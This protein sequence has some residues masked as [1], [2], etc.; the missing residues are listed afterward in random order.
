MVGALG[1][2]GTT[3]I[4]RTDLKV[5]R[6][7]RLDDPAADRPLTCLLLAPLVIS[8]PSPPAPPGAGPPDAVDPSATGGEASKFA[9]RGRRYLTRED[10][11]VVTEA[12]LRGNL[13]AKHKAVY[14]VEPDDPELRFQWA[15]AS[16]V[17]PTPD[18]PTRL[19][20]LSGRGQPPVR[21]RG[22]LGAVALAGSAELL[23][24]ALHAG[25]GQY[26]AS[27]MGFLLPETESHLL[28]V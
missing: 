2:T 9:R 14:G 10:G 27:G 6:M 4:G 18:R 7:D 1:R 19:V 28:R 15:A 5:S 11:I 23:R 13:L 16:S 17:W 20:R 25:L 3:R 22:S 8:V 24:L 26:N 21:V 12:R